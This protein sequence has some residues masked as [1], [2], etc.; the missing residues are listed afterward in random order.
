MQ[1][2]KNNSQHKHMT[3]DLYLVYQELLQLNNK[4]DNQIKNGQ[5]S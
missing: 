3:N 2:G 1:T 4:K 5:K